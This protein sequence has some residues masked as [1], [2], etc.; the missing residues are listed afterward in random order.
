M[1]PTE[2]LVAL[3]DDSLA[4]P[5]GRIVARL[6]LTIEAFFDDLGCPLSDEQKQ[7]LAAA[8]AAS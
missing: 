2:A 7:A 3:D 8:R 6:T 4:G 5:S 1:T